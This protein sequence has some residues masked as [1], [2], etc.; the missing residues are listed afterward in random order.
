M[1]T[2][3]SK[4][5]VPVK[6]ITISTISVLL[7]LVISVAFIKKE[8]G[9]LF[10]ILLAFTIFSAVFYFYA[11]SL[12]EVR[13]IDKRVIL[14]KKLSKI[15]IEFSEIISIKTIQYC[16]LPMTVGSKGVFGFIGS[17]M[18]GSI[19]FVKDRNQ[20]VKLITKSN[21]YILSCDNPKDF[22][23]TILLQNYSLSLIN[24]KTP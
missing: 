19:S 10:G 17:T 6:I 7:L 15:E 23:N 21:N 22:V 1:K 14:K 18:D 9:P 8:S 16:A 20:M 11:N 24:N 4:S 12:K 13:I 3:S 2:Y 5:S